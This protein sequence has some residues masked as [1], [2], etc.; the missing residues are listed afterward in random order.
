MKF[1]DLLNNKKA[2]LVKIC[3]FLNIQK[4]ENELNNVIKYT[5]LVHMKELEKRT[6]WKKMKRGRILKGN[7]FIRKGEAKSFLK[8]VP[9]DLIKTFEAQNITMLKKH[10]C[11]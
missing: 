10:Y 11:E 8:E 9:N 6:D 7:K 4:S 3:E 1:E 2:V 5:G